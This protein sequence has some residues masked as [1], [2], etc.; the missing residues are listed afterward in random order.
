[1]RTVKKK[2]KMIGFSTRL[3]A[4]V[5]KKL[6]SFA[7]KNKLTISDVTNSSIRVFISE[8]EEYIAEI[9]K[10]RSETSFLRPAAYVVPKAPGRVTKAYGTD[11]AIKAMKIKYG[12]S[13]L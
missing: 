7:K 2:S 6:K 11:D 5:A 9:E 3:E 13:K 8:A 1:M 4:S 10:K 12:S